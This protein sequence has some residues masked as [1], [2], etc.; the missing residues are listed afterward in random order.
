MSSTSQHSVNAESAVYDRYA[1]ASKNVEP[2]LCCPVQY[3]GEFLNVIPQE[4]IDKDYGCGDPSAW[5]SKG[6]SVVDLGSGAG[7]LCYIMAQVVGPTGS[8]TGVDCNHEMLELARKYHRQVT[9]AIGYANVEFK[10]GMIQDL[11]LDLD[12]LNQY[13]SANPVGD[14]LDWFKLRQAEE[15]LRIESPLIKS[16]SIDCVVSNCVLNL[17]RQHDRRQLFDEIFRILKPGG[18]AVIS[19]IVCNK[20]VPERLQQDGQ[21]WSGCLSG[22]FRED[23][24]PAAFIRAGFSDAQPVKRQ[25]D[26]WQIIE[27]I[28]FRS[29]TVIAWKGTKPEV[30]PGLAI[31]DGEVCC[32][33]NS[34]CC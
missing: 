22:A 14:A 30:T 11:Q 19:D 1:A 26:P 32:D 25:A 8:V 28:E 34:G 7:K 4:V 21:L 27:N 2:A 17:V 5:V 15:R 12:L 20:D 16:N 23:L 31:M 10:Y 13:L 24:F 18:R 29:M 9:D 33:S 6:E 3:A